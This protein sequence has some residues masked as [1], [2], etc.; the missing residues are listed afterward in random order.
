MAQFPIALPPHDVSRAIVA[1]SSFAFLKRQWNAFRP[2]VKDEVSY[3]VTIVAKAASVTWS[4]TGVAT[5]VPAATS[6][7][8]TA[9]IPYV[10][11][12]RIFTDL[13]REDELIEIAVSPGSFGVN[14]LVTTSSQ[15][16]VQAEEAGPALP[17][18]ATAKNKALENEGP[19]I[20]DPLDSPLGSPMLGT[21]RNFRKY[22]IQR[23]AVN[24]A[25]MKNQ[26]K[27]EEILR[28]ADKLLQP[29]EITRSDL[30]RL[31]DERCGLP[32]DEVG[33]T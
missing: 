11:I 22:G 31:L 8:F 25:F 18:K 20:I 28:K 26:K 7:A 13:P 16:L 1:G 21:Y 23:F 19:A 10:Y 14:G 4:T 30:E 27:L 12:K 15:V 24:E 9:Q 17:S 32:P 5:A 33:R 2:K 3:V 6:R 29:L